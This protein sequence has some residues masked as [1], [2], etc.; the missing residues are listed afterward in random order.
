[1][2]SL[3][4][5]PRS[6]NAQPRGFAPER[7]AD[8]SSGGEPPLQAIP[9]FE[10]A[11]RPQLVAHDEPYARL[12]GRNV[13]VF[14]DPLQYVASVRSFSRGGYEATVRLV[15]AQQLADQASLDRPRGRRIERPADV[16]SDENIWRAQV[17]ARQQVR[18]RVKEMGADRLLT[19]TTRESENTVDE[20]LL[21]WQRWLKL[22]ERASGGRFHY[23]AVPEPHPSNPKHFHLHVAVAVFLNVDVLRRCWW[24]VCGGRGM[25]NVHIKRLSAGG[26]KERRVCRVASY[27]SKYLTKYELVRFNRKRYWSSRVQLQAVRRYWLA[28]SDLCSALRETW[29]RLGVKGCSASAGDLWM[30]SGGELFWFQVMPGH[31]DPPPF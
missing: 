5:A 2:I 18:Y 10:S 1:M 4:H 19:L 16:R 7:S 13:P 27:I 24:Q 8:H 12:R 11:I 9:E 20:L 17:R 15:N 29:D 25:G 22:V 6:G 21:R 28:S 23:V 30:A 31:C 26:D 14:E 3:H